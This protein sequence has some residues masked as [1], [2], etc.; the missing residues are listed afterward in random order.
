MLGRPVVAQL[1]S[2][3]GS[4][5]R[6]RVLSRSNNIAFNNSKGVE[7]VQG[8]VQDK[9]SL[10]NAMN[11]CVGVH[12][13]LSGGSLEREGAQM[14][15][16]VASKISSL[17]RITM[18]SGVTTNAKNAKR[19]PSTAAKWDAEQTIMQEASHHGRISYTIF[20]CTMFL[21]SLPKWKYLIGDQRTKWH[22]L[23]AEDYARM[24]AH[25]YQDLLVEIHAFSSSA[26]K[27]QIF[28]L[29]GPGPARTLPE[30]IH[31]V[32]LPRKRNAITRK[33]GNS[34]TSDVVEPLVTTIPYWWAWTLQYLPWASDLNS[35]TTYSMTTTRNRG[36]NSRL[37]TRDDWSTLVTKMD[38]LSQIQEMGDPSHANAV[39]GGAPSITMEEWIENYLKKGG[40]RRDQG[41]VLDD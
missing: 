14:V 35:L 3:D 37:M 21:E 28:F 22:W 39:L 32:F 15:A 11:G 13:N 12:I 38:W 5:F 19:F 16:K 41:N 30:A 23:S 20:R 33:D 26:A 40:D 9:E 7:Y 24:V 2:L 18:I 27:N 8:N 10:F 4:P 34:T 36:G 31:Q 25:S 29:H 17:R 6:V 1:A